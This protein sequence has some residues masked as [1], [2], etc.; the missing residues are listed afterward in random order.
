MK[1]NIFAV[2]MSAAVLTSAAANAQTTTVI[3]TTPAPPPAVIVEPA[4]TATVR[5]EKTEFGIGGIL[6]SERRTT[7]DNGN[8]RRHT[9]QTN[10]LLG[11][12]SK[13]TET[14]Y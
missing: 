8:C 3:E 1:L 10:T 14:C 11:S 4:P 6:G 9:T 7:T 13:T 12:N 2:A 5:S